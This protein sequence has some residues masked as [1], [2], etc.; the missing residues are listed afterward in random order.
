MN[1]SYW[2]AYGLDM[3]GTLARLLSS[4]SSS[5]N[6]TLL[7]LLMPMG[8]GILEV[9]E[10]IVMGCLRSECVHYSSSSSSYSYRGN[11]VRGAVRCC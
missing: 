11:K 3:N 10:L 2:L 4:Y 6:A 5:N 7:E 1:E 9:T 8:S